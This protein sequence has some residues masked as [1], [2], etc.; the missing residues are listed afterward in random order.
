[1]HTEFQLGKME[2]FWGWMVITDAQQC[3]CNLCHRTIH[4]KMVKMVNCMLLFILRQNKFKI[5]YQL[6]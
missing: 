6:L 3:E 2:K 4:L 1:M 5:L